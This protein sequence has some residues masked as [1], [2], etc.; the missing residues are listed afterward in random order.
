MADRRILHYEVQEK[1]GAGGMGVV[2]KAL[3]TKLKRVVAL[4][5]LSGGLAA[6]PAQRQRFIREAMAASSL[7]HPNICTIYEINEAEDGQLFLAMAYYPGETLSQ[8]LRGG[9]LSLERTLDIAIQVA[10]A[11]ER[12]HQHGVTHRDIKP[13]NIMI[14]KGMVKVLDF[15]LAK[16]ADD[17]GLTREGEAMGTVRYMSP[18]QAT[19]KSVDPRTDIWAVGAVFYEMLTG[20]APFT[21]STSQGILHAILTQQ[22]TPVAPQFTNV[23][24]EVDWIIAKALA[25]HTKDRYTEISEMLADLE[26]IREHRQPSSARSV[27]KPLEVAAIAVLP[28][29]NL[30]G[31]KDNEYFSDGLTEEVI[32]ALAQVKGLRV[33]SRTSSFE[34]K[35]KAQDIRKIGEVLKVQTLLEGS[36]RRI[37]N[38]LRVTAQ[39][40]EVASGFHIWS[41]RY[42]SEM[43]D[44]FEIQ[45]QISAA[46]V[47]ALKVALPLNSEAVAESHPDTNLEAYQMCLKGRFYWNKK[48]PA[49]LEKAHEFFEKA[50]VEDPACALAYSGLADTYTLMAGY[51]LA[52]PSEMWPKAKAAA[53]KAIASNPQLP[54]PHAALG[55]VLTFYDRNWAEAELE[56]RKALEL[57]PQFAEAHLRYG[58][59]FMATGRLEQALRRAR[60]AHQLDPLSPSTTAAETMVLTYMGR[61]EAAIRRCKEALEM[62]PYFIE[63]RYV[64]GMAYQRLGRFDDAIAAFEAGATISGREPLFLCWLGAAYAD[65]GRRDQALEILEELKQRENDGGPPLHLPFAVVYTALG[66]KNEAFE[67][68][69]RAADAFDGLV[70]YIQI[71]PTYDSLRDDPRYLELLTRLGMTPVGDPTATLHFSEDAPAQRA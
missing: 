51:G 44:V 6:D 27:S 64:L 58:F 69:F 46:I 35:G 63:L 13:A 5:F 29:E 10:R 4:K 17:A 21:G 71:V 53:L 52:P 16:L 20:V 11:L 62:H 54:E 15:G 47:D 28:F 32:N 42:D 57:R 50:L 26:A 23:P 19:G 2:H 60:I 24:P 45:D 43:S 48:T 66:Q 30:S 3:D 49:G 65:A 14:T 40:T 37:G 34:F 22:V 56:F 67:R 59:Y 9:P 61:S 8:M 12:A 18:E 68:L 39:L 70:C 31:D 1:I 36:V 7:D 38:R 33:V 25:K 41:H 55:S